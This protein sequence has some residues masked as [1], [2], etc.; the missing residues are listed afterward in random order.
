LSTTLARPAVEHGSAASRGSA[1]LD[2][3]LGLWDVTTITIGSI[4]GSAIFLAAAF[5]PREVPQP[6][7]VLLLW[8]AGGAISVAGALCYAELG[9]MFPEAGGQYHYLKQSFGP[10]WGFL[11]GWTSLLAIQ[12]GGI[13]F[14]GVAFG[15]YLGAFFPFF[16]PTHVVAS[17]PVGLWT[18]E[19][20][21]AQIAGGLAIAVLS[22]VNYVGTKEGAAV[23]GF[24]S[25]MKL[26]SLGGLILFGLIAPARVT[27][28]WVAPLPHA[29][30]W[31]AMALALVAVVGNFDGW[32]QAT[33]SAGEIKR[34]ERNLPLG[35]IGGTAVVGLLYLLV[36]V[37]YFRALPVA[38][39]GES[40]RIGEEA[41]TALLGPAAGRSLAAVVLVSIFGC[42]SSTIIGASRLG[43]PMAEEAP[44]LR[45]LARIHPRY[46]TP[47][48]GIVTLGVWSIGLVLSGSYEA[49]FNYALFASF[50][51]HGITA[52]ALFT[53]RRQQ[54]QTPRP[55]RVFG[56]PYVPA[57]FL[58]AMI[59]LV[60][61]TLRERPL[62][63]LL[64][65]GIVAIGVPLFFWRPANLQK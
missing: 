65:V 29:N 21:T 24:L 56:Y 9:A 53:L 13:A 43:L 49:L 50:I 55:Y 25:A 18:W 3:S 40:T 47:T 5:V 36:N 19:P 17:I 48:T 12:S 37:V 46:R 63:S 28:D 61:N 38:A 23:Q 4:V 27:V 54:P 51:F 2:R 58:V 14:L 30:V 45:W 33:L 16:S 42:I 35:M 15:S 1:G 60:L 62:E 20:S 41:T 59:G 32:Y 64:G 26:L 44:A 10:L 22:A 34:P 39:F 57:V 6:T 8:I 7:L 11:F 31:T 52:I